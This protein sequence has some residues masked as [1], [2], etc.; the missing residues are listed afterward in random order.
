MQKQIKGLMKQVTELKQQKENQGSI[1][2]LSY[3]KPARKRSRQ[4]SRSKSRQ[5]SISLPGEIQQLEVMVRD[6]RNQ[7]FTTKQQNEK[8]TS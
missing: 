4:P 2:R 7:L 8:L 3:D 5:P 6:L 1:P